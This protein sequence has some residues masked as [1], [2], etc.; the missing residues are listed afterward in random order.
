MALF[1]WF[2]KAKNNNQSHGFASSTELQNDQSTAMGNEKVH[3][4]LQN[5]WN[6]W[7]QVIPLG[8]G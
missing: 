2:G 4:A 7:S 5:Q 3:D 6:I 1:D 8:V